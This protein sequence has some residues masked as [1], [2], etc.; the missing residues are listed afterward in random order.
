M[1]VLLPL[2]LAPF[3]LSSAPVLRAA[4]PTPAALGGAVLTSHGLVGV[5]RL[6]HNLRDKFGE[7][8]GSFSALAFD[9]GSWRRQADGSYT[10]TLL[11]QPD[12][13]YNASFTTNYTPRLNLIAVHFVPSATGAATQDQVALTLRDTIRY[14]DPA[15][16][17]LTSLDPTPAGSG[18]RPG[19]PVLPQAFNG[20]VSLDAEGLAIN[21]D[22]THW[23]SDE[24][25]PYLYKFSREGKMLAAIR[26]PEA[27]IPKRH[28]ADS[29]A[30]NSPGRGQPAPDPAEPDT[31]RQDNQGFEGLGLSPDG[32]LLFALLQSA[33]RQDGGN[34]GS[35]P[36]ANTRLLIYD[37]TGAAPTL[38]AEYVLPLPTFT[39]KAATRV[40]AQSDLLV[41]GK[42]RILVLARDSNVGRGTA[43]ASVFRQIVA[44]DLAGATNLAHTAFDQPDH[45]VAPRGILDPSIK[46]AA[47]TECLDLNDPAQLARF[48]LHNGAPD[49]AN[50]L[51]EKWE[52]MALVPALDPAAPD[53]WFLFVGNDNDFLTTQGFQD[54]ADYKA[55]VDNDSMILVYRVTLKK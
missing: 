5:G 3:L 13:G 31:G 50:N 9:P 53:D 47:R 33:T 18:R 1:R 28:G 46:P 34:G 26:P 44:Y 30:A 43:A 11:A 29:F 19:F 8:F 37:L 7:T 24:Y 27:F 14:T 36:R 55:E 35:S 48:G 23:V 54:R 38:S 52:G 32:R 42:T 17:P 22:G 40:A 20:R 4:D 49:D 25:G 51:S 6:P 45:P 16:T 15:G 41:L 12:R 10:G 21:A 39:Q 2:C